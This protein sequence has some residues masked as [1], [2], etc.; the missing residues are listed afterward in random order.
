[1]LSIVEFLNARYDELAGHAKVVDE[2]DLQWLAD[3]GDDVGFPRAAAF[4]RAVAPPWVLA[5]IEAKRRIVSDYESAAFTLSVAGAGTPPFDIMTGAV[6]TLKR[7]LYYLAL[8]Y[9]D[10]PDFDPGWKL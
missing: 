1:M 3:Y 2:P 7:M 4:I 6:N 9:A 10:H 5:E 8:P